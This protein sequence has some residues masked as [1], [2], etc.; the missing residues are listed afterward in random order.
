[1]SSTT[2]RRRRGTATTARATILGVVAATRLLCRH[3]QPSRAPCDPLVAVSEEDASADPHPSSPNSATG[4]GRRQDVLYAGSTKSVSNRLLVSYMPQP[5]TLRRSR[6]S[7]ALALRPP[8]G[9]I[10]IKDKASQTAR[11]ADAIARR[12]VYH[13]L[14]GRF[15]KLVCA[16]RRLKA[17]A[18]MWITPV[19]DI[20]MT[21]PTPTAATVPSGLQEI[22]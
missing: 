12:G 4:Q 15:L 2:S 18:K 16:T 1:M 5:I 17:Y 13:R 19:R 8:V 10:D 22:N 14:A 6:V 11:A 9:R 21:R 3:T 20:C 7:V